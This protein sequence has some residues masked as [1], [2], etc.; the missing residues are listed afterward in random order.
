V[1]IY[2]GIVATPLFKVDVPLS[3]HSIGFATEAARSETND[4]V[5]S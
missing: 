5:E 1:W 4:H 3:S 2:H